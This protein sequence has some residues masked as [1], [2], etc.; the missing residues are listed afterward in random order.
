[1]DPEK[2]SLN[3]IF[4]TKYIIPKSLKFSHWPSKLMVFDFQGI[5]HV[6]WDDDPFIP[7][8][9]SVDPSV[10]P[11]LTYNVPIGLLWIWANY[12]SIIPKPELKDFGEI[13]LR[14]TT[15]W[16][17]LGGLVAIICPDEW[18]WKAL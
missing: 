5:N 17:D 9:R 15:I 7:S 11:F 13:P 4:P 10:D 18:S 12:Y 1:M 16:G 14:F 6:S 8:P 2:K 3:F